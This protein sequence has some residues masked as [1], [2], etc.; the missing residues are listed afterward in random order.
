MDDSKFHTTNPL[1][2]KEDIENHYGVGAIIHD[3]ENP[4]LILLLWHNKYQFWTMPIGKVPFDQDTY[5]GLIKE[6]EEE[7]GIWIPKVE[8]MGSF[9]KRYHRGNDIYTT[10]NSKLYNVPIYKGYI[11]NKEPQKHRELKW[12]SI[13]NIE[14]LPPETTS[15]MLK[16]WLA[17][18]AL[19]ATPSKKLV[20]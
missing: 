8:F 16:F 6:M 14:G 15:D 18:V 3:K 11:E 17:L 9:V 20:E 12:M 19:Q 4:D 10:V 1:V 7:L 2:T 13:N 5:N